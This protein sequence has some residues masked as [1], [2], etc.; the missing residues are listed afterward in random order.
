MAGGHDFPYVSDADHVDEYSRCDLG[1]LI[2]SGKKPFLKSTE[3]TLSVPHGSTKCKAEQLAL[4][5]D[6]PS[7]K[8]RVAAIRPAAIYGE[9]ETRHM[10]R[11]LQTLNSGARQI[12]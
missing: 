4:A 7:R 1:R 12:I 5:A 9:H 8:F 2:V 6:S 11:I 10:P 3:L